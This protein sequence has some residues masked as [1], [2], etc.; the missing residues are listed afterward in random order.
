MRGL[1]GE[2][3]E[4]LH[5]H[6]LPRTAAARATDMYSIEPIHANPSSEAA[7][8]GDAAPVVGRRHGEDEAVG[9]DRGQTGARR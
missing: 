2:L 3:L 6:R 4:D 8:L 7:R 9:A 5:R 1:E